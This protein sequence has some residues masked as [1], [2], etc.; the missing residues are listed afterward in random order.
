M[1]NLSKDTIN[2][3]NSALVKLTSSA[4]R[5]FAAELCIK[6]FDSSPRKMERT[7]KVGRAMVSLGLAE[8]H[9][10]ITCSSAF[11]LRGA[12]KKNRQTRI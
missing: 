10:G 8:Y 5:C 1:A 3:F 9:S 2:S 11:T 7:L 4:R 6:Y 12:K